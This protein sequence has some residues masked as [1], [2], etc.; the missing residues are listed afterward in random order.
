[1]QEGCPISIAVSQR[2]APAANRG[3]AGESATE[4]WAAACTPLEVESLQRRQKMQLIEVPLMFCLCAQRTAC[5]GLFVICAWAMCTPL[6]PATPATQHLYLSRQS[7]VLPVARSPVNVLCLVRSAPAKHQLD[8]IDFK[9]HSWDCCCTINMHAKRPVWPRGAAP[10]SGI[11]FQWTV[12]LNGRPR[13]LKPWSFTMYGW[14]SFR[15]F[16]SS[17]ASSYER[18][19][20]DIDTVQTT[21][22]CSVAWI[23]HNDCPLML[24]HPVMHKIHIDYTDTLQTMQISSRC[25]MWSICYPC[26]K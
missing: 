10:T 4:C 7:R 23:A 18:E 6:A 5:F 12:R 20:A 14:N 24:H 13:R 1:M 16:P 11:T 17:A 8:A 25:R 9:R 22:V 2:S 3:P 19:D 21:C 15:S 26:F